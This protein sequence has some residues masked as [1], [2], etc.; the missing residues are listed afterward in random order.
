MNHTQFMPYKSQRKTLKS[1]QNFTTQHCWDYVGLIHEDLNLYYQLLPR[2]GRIINE[3]HFGLDV[4]REVVNKAQDPSQL[5]EQQWSKSFPCALE[6]YL[7]VSAMR[8]GIFFKA[9]S[10]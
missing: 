7:R 4:V 3:T 1:I 2:E 10:V 9:L 8:Q 6:L 5:V